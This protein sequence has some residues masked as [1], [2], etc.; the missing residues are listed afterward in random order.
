MWSDNKK[1]PCKNLTGAILTDVTHNYQF[2]TT[3]TFAIIN[4]STFFPHHF[5][6]NLIHYKIRLPEIEYLTISFAAGSFNSPAT[7]CTFR[8][9]IELSNDIIVKSTSPSKIL[10]MTKFI[11]KLISYNSYFYIKCAKRVF[12]VHEKVFYAET[13][14]EA[15]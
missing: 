11:P 13:K 1:F 8:R 7:F 6:D 9:A 10:S 4:Q 15:V 14:V 12:F 2:W 3:I 5:K